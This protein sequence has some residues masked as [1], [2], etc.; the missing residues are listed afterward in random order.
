MPKLNELIPFRRK[1][2]GLKFGVECEVEGQGLPN[3]VGPLFLVEQDGSLRNGGLEY[4]FAKPLDKANSIKALEG[5]FG[6]FVKQKSK[7]DYSFR[8]STHVHVNVSDIEVKKVLNI[9]FLYTL[10]EDLFV[11]FCEEHRRGNRFA[12]RFKEA[13]RLYAVLNNLI[14]AV[15]CD[16]GIG[17]MADMFMGIEQNYTKYA[18]LNMYTLVKYGTL[19]FRSLEGTNDLKKISKWIDAIENIVRVGKEFE[20]LEDLHQAFFNDPEAIIDAIFT[21]DFKFEGWQRAVEESY[22]QAYQVVLASKGI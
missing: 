14:G 6:Q 20:T 7:L 9:I 21:K 22:S 16:G 15:Y 19:E 5:L 13:E 2:D 1:I 11:N 3:E 8:T 4:V 12:L 17:N 18:A 10:V